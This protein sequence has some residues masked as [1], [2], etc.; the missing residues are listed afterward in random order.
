MYAGLP[1][2]IFP[3][4]GWGPNSPKLSKGIGTPTVNFILGQK[5]YIA[6]FQSR[7]TFGQGRS[8]GRAKGAI[9]PGP[10]T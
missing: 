5:C 9:Y 2:A 7:D 1:R 10:H 8:E 4:F 3:R 6:V